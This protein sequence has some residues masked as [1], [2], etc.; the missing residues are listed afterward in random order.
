MRKGLFLFLATLL[1]LTNLASAQEEHQYRLFVTW[2]VEGV[3]L[4]VNLLGEDDTSTIYTG[5]TAELTWVG[6]KNACIS[7]PYFNVLPD[8][9]TG[10]VAVILTE[11]TLFKTAFIVPFS[12]STSSFCINPD[13]LGDPMLAWDIIGP[14][15]SVPLTIT[16]DQDSD[17][18]I[19]QFQREDG[20]LL[21]F[22]NEPPYDPASSLLAAFPVLDKET[23]EGMVGYDIPLDH[24][25]L[26]EI[27]G[28][29]LML[30]SYMIHDSNGDASTN[31]P[32]PFIVAVYENGA[33]AG[34][35]FGQLHSD[36]QYWLMSSYPNLPYP[37]DLPPM[38]LDL[39]LKPL[40]NLAP[41][42]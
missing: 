9:Y 30:G 14:A 15:Q 16:T 2:D 39:L 4:V 27:P 38:D 36:M 25:F 18:L 19:R 6:V 17:L 13:N 32:T 22:Y 33:L 12:D 11:D 42:G 28:Q 40:E 7:P 29:L 5:N 35:Y 26:V 41:P 8:T 23:P 20:T 24:D 37:E 3:G 1:V 31:N 21:F 34:L 10:H